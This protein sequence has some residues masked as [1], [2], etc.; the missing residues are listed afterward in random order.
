M[1]GVYGWADDDLAFVPGCIVKTDDVAC[2]MG[3]DPVEEIGENMRWLRD[4]TPPPGC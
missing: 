1:N 4:G 3:G 2:H